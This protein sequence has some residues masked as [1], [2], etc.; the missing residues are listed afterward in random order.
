MPNLRFAGAGVEIGDGLG[1]AAVE[2]TGA[3]LVAVAAEVAAGLGA[4]GVQAPNIN[5]EANAITRALE[6][7]TKILN[8]LLVVARLSASW[9]AGSS[10]PGPM[11]ITSQGKISVC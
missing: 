8:L 5:N 1:A 3:G 7:L 10:S 4:A 9:A 11:P 2:V 6:I